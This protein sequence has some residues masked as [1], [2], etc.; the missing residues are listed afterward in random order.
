MAKCIIENGKYTKI[1]CSDCGCIFSF[2]K[3]VDIEEDG[4]V[5]CPECGTKNTPT[6]K[7]G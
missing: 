5:T 6:V 4:K 2:D 7:K 1:T 3:T